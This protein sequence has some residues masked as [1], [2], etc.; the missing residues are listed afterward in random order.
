MGLCFSFPRRRLHPAMGMGGMGGMGMGMPLLV[1][2]TEVE[3][4]EWVAWKVAG[5]GDMGDGVVA[6]RAVMAMPRGSGVAGTEAQ[7]LEG[8]G[9]AVPR[10]A[11]GMG[12][13]LVEAGDAERCSSP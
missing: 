13:D 3:W 4:E 1:D 9:S 8:P 10:G 11:L 2:I 7:G 12:D 5:T 6:R